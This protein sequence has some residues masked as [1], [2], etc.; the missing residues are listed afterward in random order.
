VSCLTSIAPHFRGEALHPLRTLSLC[1]GTRRSPLKSA[2]PC[3]AALGV[4]AS[5]RRIEGWMIE[6][7][8]SEN[9][10]TL[11]EQVLSYRESLPLKGL[12]VS[13]QKYPFLVWILRLRC[14]EMVLP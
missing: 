8:G 6:A 3:L 2:P 11:V 9:G 1:A 5:S 12:F 7:L 10:L 14:P 13:E 4:R